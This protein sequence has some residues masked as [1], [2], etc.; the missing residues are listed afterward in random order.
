MEST[1]KL[2]DLTLVSKYYPVANYSYPRSRR[3]GQYGSRG[4]ID[5]A[6]F[7]S[8]DSAPGLV[9]D[10]TDSE[11]STEDDYQYHAHATELWDTFWH[12]GAERKQE[13][14]VINPKRQYPALIPSPQQQKKR[15]V[16]QESLRSWPLPELPAHSRGKRPTATYSPFPK[17]MLL[18]ARSTRPVP[19]WTSSRLG[20]T[21][22]RPPRPDNDLLIPCARDPVLDAN[23]KVT[24]AQDYHGQSSSNFRPMTPQHQRPPPLSEV[25]RPTTS[26]DG[27]CEAKFASSTSSMCCLSPS[28]VSSPRYESHE[29]RYGSPSP[30]L[31]DS[32]ELEPQSVFECDDSDT[33][34]QSPS[35]SFF[36]FH[37]RAHSDRPARS[38]ELAT[39]RRRRSRANTTPPRSR[40][41]VDYAINKP[42]TPTRKRQVDVWGRMLG[43]R[44]K[45]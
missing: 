23:A 41:Q 32:Q 34:I 43:R 16:S 27:H 20:R 24:Q 29:A 15:H 10:R 25:Q 2:A 39:A 21:P 8:A 37:K 33:E 6:S 3:H 26:M 4:S 9:E 1:S 30:A 35:R 19:S 12:S 11:T 28:I 31:P 14:P 44:S 18:P 22:P 38:Q 13:A 40:L 36:S 17:P 7:G 45:G 42:D 5:R